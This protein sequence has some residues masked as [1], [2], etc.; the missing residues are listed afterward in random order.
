MPESSS[1]SSSSSPRDSEGRR[2][3]F[4]T[5]GCKL[6]QF[7][8]D[9]LASRFQKSGYVIEN[10]DSPSDVYVINTCTVTGKADRKSRNMIRR[11]LRNSERNK[12]LVVVTGCFA[13]A[14][15]EE[16]EQDPRLYVVDNK[17]KARIFQLVESHLKKE[18]LH[19]AESV[20]GSV[21][22][23]GFSERIYHTRGM[24]KIQDGCD[25]FCT[26]CIIPMVRGRAVSRPPEVVT[27]NVRQLIDSGYREVVLT[28]VNMSRYSRDGVSFS[29]LLEKILAVPGDFRV[30]ISSLEP[31]SPDDR[32]LDLL[33][34]PKMCPHLHLCLQ[35]GS[36]RILLLMRRQYSFEDYRRIVEKLRKKCPDFNITTDMIVGFPGE[37]EADF[38]ESC[39]AVEEIR[40]S[41]V[42]V[43][44]YSRR[45]GTPADKMEHHVSEEQ[46]N[47]RSRILR[48]SALSLKREYYRSWLGRRQSFL[49][50]SV[51]KDPVSGAYRGSGFGEHY[52]PLKVGYAREE[53][54]PD[55]NR[56]SSVYLESL[57]DSEEPFLRGL[58]VSPGGGRD[59]NL[60]ENRK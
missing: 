50:E 41:H 32:F 22:E 27:D 45:R 35:S 6:N 51:Q 9:A 28:G 10:F 48:D 54:R 58:I 53:G 29:S 13:T 56:F 24:V 17:Q 21:F 20:Q 37:N 38:R 18:I 43:F 44:K 59:R 2:V 49:L 4:Q 31:E 47:E 11:A 15:K 16:L 7:E 36:E 34:H 39:R 57:E 55:L 3:A 23:Y 5:L 26:F 60:R 33:D 8:T 25:N 1:P 40:P 46:K 30:R 14:Q 19:P 52:I 42:H 12:G